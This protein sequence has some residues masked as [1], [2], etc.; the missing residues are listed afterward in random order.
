MQNP[1]V[2]PEIEN[3]GWYPIRAFS[4]MARIQD[5]CNDSTVSKKSNTA[6]Y[7]RYVCAIASFPYFLQEIPL[8]PRSAEPPVP[9]HLR[10]CP[11]AGATSSTL[12]IRRL[13]G[14][15]R[16]KTKNRK[17]LLAPYP[18]NSFHLQTLHCL[19]SDLTIQ[20]HFPPLN[21]M[22]KQVIQ[23]KAAAYDSNDHQNNSAANSLRQ[24]VHEA[25]AEKSACH[26]KISDPYPKQAPRQARKVYIAQDIH[27][28]CYG[29]SF[30]FF[31][32]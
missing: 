27:L 28:P 1:P 9:G 5:V 15:V 23:E 20:D 13:A 18:A 12:M 29:F 26:Q 17:K 7:V 4:H 10:M 3:G 16:Y 11:A 8:L 14:K 19:G 30:P 24:Q 6:I 2:L 31:H 21:V 25:Q 32:H 22:C